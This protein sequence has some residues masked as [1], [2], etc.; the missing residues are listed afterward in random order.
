MAHEVC[1]SLRDLRDDEREV[2]GGDVQGHA[3][4]WR[5]ASPGA[6]WVDRDR[7]VA[8]RRQRCLDW[9]EV[10]A[11]PCRRRHHHDR[12]AVAFNEHLELHAAG[13]VLEERHGE[14]TKWTGIPGVCGV[15]P[16]HAKLPAGR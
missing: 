13:G 10:G 16:G 6:S 14:V 8:S 4:R 9:S 15:L 12:F 1:T 5:R 2:V 11:A 3:G 7:S